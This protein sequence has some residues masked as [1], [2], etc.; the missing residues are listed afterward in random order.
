MEERRVRSLGR[1]DP[2]EKEMA[3]HFS[4]VA[5]RI[6][7]TEEPGGL[8]YRGS[9]RVR[10]DWSD[11]AHM[12]AYTSGEHAHASKG[13]TERSILLHDMRKLLSISHLLITKVQSVIDLLPQ[14]QQKAN[15]QRWHKLNIRIAISL[16]YKRFSNYLASAQW[17]PLYSCNPKHCHHADCV[18]IS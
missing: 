1:E 11:L 7:W 14:R 8:Q 15:L 13:G 12:H 18:Q 3:T 9:H 17:M 2:L 10:H 5:W 6:P 16:N 4:I